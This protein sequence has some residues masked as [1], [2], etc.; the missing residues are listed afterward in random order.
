MQK[1]QVEIDRLTPLVENNVISEVQLKTAKAAHAA[2]AAM[3]DQAKA[4]VGNAQINIGYTY[5][6]AP[7]SG[8]VGR[9]PY[10]TG[11]LVGKGES[12]PLTLLSDASEIYA[13]FF[14]ERTGFHCI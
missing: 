12:E 8:Y 3:A 6:K 14:F 9:F 2:A 13:L 10:K 11:S 4:Q 5:I 1:A 7:V